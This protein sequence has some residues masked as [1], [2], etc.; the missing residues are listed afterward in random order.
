MIDLFENKTMQP[1]LIRD[2]IPP[3]DDKDFIYEL[4][5]DGCRCIA[6][7]DKD[8]TVLKNKRNVRLDPIFPE[9]NE[10]HRQVKKRCVLDGEL[11]VLIDGKPEFEA[12]QRRTIMSNQIKIKLVSDKS[13]AS[14]VAYDILYYDKGAVMNLPL[15]KR[16]ELLDANVNENERI[17]VSRWIETHG[18][19]L[20]NL[21][22][23]QNLE[24]VVGKRKDSFYYPGKHTKD[25]VKMKNMLDDDF[26]VCGYIYKENNLVSVVLGQ[27]NNEE[28][29]YKGHV[30]F[31]VRGENFRRIKQLRTLTSPPFTRSIPST[32]ENA[33]WVEPTI[34]CTVK[35]MDYTNNGQMRQP[36]LKGIRDDKLPN[37]CTVKQIKGY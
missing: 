3:F 29:I 18:I 19:E 23:E 33:V 4:K 25:W 2:E 21:T 12:L 15:L 5:W 14:F 20:F 28:L 9:L 36:V 17:A 34:V 27:Y 1:M 31:G 6:Y 32:N 35:F 16:K 37:E 11:I 13:P 24:G 8:G 7:L 10:I 30:T 26:V 22:T